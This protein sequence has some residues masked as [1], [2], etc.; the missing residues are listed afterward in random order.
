MLRTKIGVG[1][2]RMFR[3]MMLAHWRVASWE[4]ANSD[5]HPRAVFPDIRIVVREPGRFTRGRSRG[6]VPP[7]SA[8]V[9]MTPAIG[10]GIPESVKRHRTS[11]SV[12]KKPEVLPASPMK[13][14]PLL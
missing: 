14:K 3:S 10:A 13:A 9:D 2:G 5:G 11:S 6:F 1:L 12:I 4:V 7:P 8:Q